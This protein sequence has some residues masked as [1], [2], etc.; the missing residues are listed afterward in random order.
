MII[1]G[2]L[3]AV[4]SGVFNGLFTAP[5]K[6]IT[7]WKWENIWLVFIV[8]ACLLMPV[9]MVAVMGPNPGGLYAAAPA[10]A[11]SSA[12]AVW[13]CLGFWSHPLWA[14]RGLPR[15]IAGQQPGHRPEFGHGIAGPPDP[16]SPV[17]A[18]C[19]ADLLV[20]GYCDL[21]PG[22]H[23]LRHGGPPARRGRRSRDDAGKA[24][25]GVFLLHRLRHHIRDLQHRLLPGAAH[26]RHGCAHGI[27]RSSPPPI[28]SGC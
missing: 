2:V 19:A 18:E 4:V 3:L 20:A 24:H 22:C 21:P 14:E 27:S 28:P 12:L 13:L 23:S 26:R 25:Q 17:A 10:G 15:S 1:A 8:T 9:G 11:V 7:G 5:M 6:M 16:P